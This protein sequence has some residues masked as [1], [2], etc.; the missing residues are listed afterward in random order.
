MKGL[1]SPKPTSRRRPRKSDTRYRLKLLVRIVLLGALVFLFA[2]GDYGLI[3][4]VSLKRKEARLRAEIT[5]L[6]SQREILLRECTL[7]ESNLSAIEKYAREELG[8]VKPGERV[9][10]VLNLS[11]E[12]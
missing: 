10:Q 12:P 2:R 1:M 6:Q 11:Q 9:Y 4:I 3:K 8:M 7:L 5:E